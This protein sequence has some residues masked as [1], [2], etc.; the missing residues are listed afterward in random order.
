VR[1]TRVER[2]SVLNLDPRDLIAIVLRTGAVYIFLLVALRLAGNCC[3]R[4]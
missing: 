3:V 4:Q 2:S 1:A